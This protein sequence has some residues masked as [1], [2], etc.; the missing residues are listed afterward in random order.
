MEL[1][2]REFKHTKGGIVFNK[3]QYAGDSNIYILYPSISSP[4]WNATWLQC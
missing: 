3:R 2:K 4:D 1:V